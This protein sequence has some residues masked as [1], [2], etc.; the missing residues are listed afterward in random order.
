MEIPAGGILIKY[1]FEK[2]GV[3]E[4]IA[5]TTIF[6]GFDLVIAVLDMAI[7]GLKMQRA[8]HIN[9]AAIAEMQA[10]ANVQHALR[11]GGSILRG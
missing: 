3:T 11:N 6:K 2:Q 5:N 8:Q 4:I 7:D 1:D 9:Q 10:Q